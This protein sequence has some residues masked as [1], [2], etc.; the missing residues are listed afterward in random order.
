MNT[1]KV[2]TLAFACLVLTAMPAMAAGSDAG[3]Y[4]YKAG[5]SMAIISWICFL[6]LLLVG[7]KVAW[8]PILANLDA[9]EKR[10]RESLENA[11]RIEKQ[12]AEAEESRKKLLSDADSSAKAIVTEAKEAAV[13]IAK[14]IKDQAQAEAT[15]QRESALKDIENAR[16]QAVSSLRRESADLAVTLAGKLIGENL[17]SEKSRVLTDKLIDNL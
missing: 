5:G 8:K 10:I 17:D 13:K 12:L 14:E 6:T 16:A 1:V 11:E 9:R 15:A 4:G 2:K 3:A 7:G